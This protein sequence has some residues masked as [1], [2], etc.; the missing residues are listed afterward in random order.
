MQKMCLRN[1]N[2]TLRLTKVTAQ[3]QC[4][5]CFPVLFIQLS[6]KQ[7]AQNG[8]PWYSLEYAYSQWNHKSY[9]LVFM[10][11]DSPQCENFIPCQELS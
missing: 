4:K 3:Y 6:C 1:M 2:A 5:P 10:K 9:S 7:A 11:I 8:F